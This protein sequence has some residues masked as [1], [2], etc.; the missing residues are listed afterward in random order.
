M[1]EYCNFCGKTEAEVAKLINGPN[2]AICDECVVL[3]VDVLD[4]KFVPGELSRRMKAY[5]SARL[6]EKGGRS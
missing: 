2:V 4:S 1:S 3:C 5:R 6:A